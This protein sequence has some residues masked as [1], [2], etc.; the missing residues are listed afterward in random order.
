MIN[1]LSHF[2]W[3]TFDLENRWSRNKHI[4]DEKQALEKITNES[5]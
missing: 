4:P 2:I 1:D 5:H 3:F